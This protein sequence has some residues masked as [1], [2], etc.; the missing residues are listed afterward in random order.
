MDIVSHPA[1]TSPVQPLSNSPKSSH[2]FPSNFNSVSSLLSS[3][4]NAKV[5]FSAQFKCIFGLQ[6]AYGLRISEVLSLRMQD[7]DVYGYISIPS[8]KRSEHRILHYP[9]ILP[10]Y[11][12]EKQYA[13]TK[14]F[15]MSYRQYYLI[16]KRLGI[17][18]KIH[19]KSVNYTVTHLARHILFNYLQIKFNLTNEQ[20]KSFSGHKSMKGLL[21]YLN[22]KNNKELAGSLINPNQT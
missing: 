3:I 10:Y 5:Q 20:V 6:S 12:P 19:P 2:V 1:I 11:T 22:S 7:V 8:K 21:Y 18:L 16:L 14:L 4:F 13:N 15:W 17:M 9:D